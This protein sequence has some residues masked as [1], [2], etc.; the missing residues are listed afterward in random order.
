MSLFGFLRG[1]RMSMGATSRGSETSMSSRPQSNSISIESLA[2]SNSITPD[3]VSPPRLDLDHDRTPTQKKSRK[4][5]TTLLDSEQTAEVAQKRRKI[6]ATATRQNGQKVHNAPLAT[7]QQRAGMDNTYTPPTNGSWISKF[8][9]LSSSFRAD[10]VLVKQEE[11]DD[12]D[13]QDLPIKTV[14]KDSEADAAAEDSIVVTGHKNYP[15]EDDSGSDGND[16]NDDSGLYMPEREKGSA[17]GQLRSADNVD[18]QPAAPASEIDAN[19]DDDNE[20]YDSDE[21]EFDDHDET[22]AVEENWDWLF[23]DEPPAPDTATAASDAWPVD[24]EELAAYEEGVASVEGYENNWTADE[25]RLHRLLALRGFHPLLPGTWTRDFLGV[26]MYP[27]LFAPLDDET[28]ASRPVAISNYG[29]QFHATKALRALFDLQARVSGLRQTGHNTARIGAIIERELRRYITW[30]AAD[31]GLDQCGPLAAMPNIAAKRFLVGADEKRGRSQGRGKKP[32]ARRVQEFFGDWVARYR[33]YYATLPEYK[34]EGS[35]GKETQRLRPP[36]LLYGFVIVQH[37]V[38]LLVVDAA[39]PESG[40]YEKI[41]TRTALG[42]I[43][44]K[45]RRQPHPRCLADFN[46]SQ[47]DRWLDASLNVAIPVHVA[48]AAQM[49]CR[50]GLVLP[51]TR[52]D[53]VDDDA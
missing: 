36:R 11:N 21:D 6:A 51:S 26:P 52:V 4:R 13:M 53:A 20:Y 49:R 29:S 47:G 42:P 38:M 32:L 46:L 10:P 19:D 37:A 28:Q 18:G 7:P 45:R 9:R 44:R 1:R 14:E 17:K 27:Y 24:E 25:K 33:S 12:V 35:N 16:D 15:D 34:V 30:A 22:D 5:K 31:A 23:E 50:A 3:S 2:M 40:G 41:T 48:R 39:S 8:K 43:R